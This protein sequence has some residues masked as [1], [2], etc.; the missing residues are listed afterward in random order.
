MCFPSW[1]FRWMQKAQRKKTPKGGSAIQQLVLMVPEPPMLQGL[2]V[3]RGATDNYWFCG[4]RPIYT[5]KHQK[6]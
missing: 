2:D 4:V 5:S 1:L 6:T 3:T